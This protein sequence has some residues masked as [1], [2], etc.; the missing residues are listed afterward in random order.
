MIRFNILR[1]KWENAERESICLR[2]ISKLTVLAFL[3]FCKVFDVM[4]KSVDETIEV[5]CVEITEQVINLGQIP[6]IQQLHQYQS[7]YFIIIRDT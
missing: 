2:L 4:E 1:T 5:G 6:I 7:K 3:L